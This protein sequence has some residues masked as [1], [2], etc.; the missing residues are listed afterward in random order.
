MKPPLLPLT[1]AVIDLSTT[2]DELLFSL[3]ALQRLA[4][5]PVHR[6]DRQQLLHQALLIAFDSFQAQR[7][8][9]YTLPGQPQARI[10][11]VLVMQQGTIPAQE[12]CDCMEE[13]CIQQVLETQKMQNSL[14]CASTM[15]CPQQ[16]LSRHLLGIPL[17][18]QDTLGGV[19]LL[20]RPAAVPFNDWDQ[21]LIRLLCLFLGQQYGLCQ[22]S[23]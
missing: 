16:D 7:A 12:P 4:E 5:L 22:Q 6:F 13:Y 20:S 1:D 15:D 23:G 19:L 14:A 9:Y 17:L 21:R 18:C 8:A 10:G 2:F 3:S 11:T